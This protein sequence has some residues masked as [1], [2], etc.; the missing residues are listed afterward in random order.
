MKKGFLGLL[1]YFVLVCPIW[2]QGKRK[3][4]KSIAPMDVAAL[5]KSDS[6]RLETIIIDA[7]RELILD[8]G[9]K[10]LQLYKSA[11]ELSPNNPAVN[12]KIA[13]ILIKNG[14]SDQALL[15]AKKA[16]AGD[17]SNKYYL[18]LAAEAYKA[19]SDFKKASEI[20]AQMI[21]TVPGTESY[22]FDLAVLYQYQGEDEKALEAYDKAE[23]IFGMNEMV[24]HEKQ[25]IYLR[26]KDYESLIGDWDKL[27][28]ENKENERHT[29]ELCEFLISNRMFEE[30]KSRLA[31]LDGNK[32]ADLLMIR[33]LMIEGKISEAIGMAQ[34]TINSE[35]ASYM[36]KLRLLDDFLQYVETIEEYEQIT[37]FASRLTDQ[38]PRQYEVQAYAGDVM[39]RLGKEEEAIAY[40]LKAVSLDPSKYN[41]WQ[42][43]LN[44]EA[45]LGQY[46]SLAKHAE[47]AL[48]YFPNQ[49]A[50]YY[51][52]G[53]GHL[54]N[55]NYQKS[56][57]ML[58]QGIKYTKDPKFS[59]VFYGYIGDAHNGMKNHEKSYRAY[60]EALKSN[61]DNDHVLNN[62]SYFLS[63]RN[64]KMDKAL[65]M[66]SK[67]MEQYPD[68]P[69]YLDTHG[70]VLYV[71]GRYKEAIVYLRKATN[72]QENGTIIEHYGDVL[73][74]LGKVEDAVQQWK[75]ASKLEGVSKKIE[76]KIANKKLYE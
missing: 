21:E 59:T 43:I 71:M 17:P 38:Y 8:N 50:L 42:N 61:P 13:E 33:L 40:Y 60:E 11:L 27:V 16:M 57:Q 12:F 6:L 29:I 1:I 70:W 46:D 49:A 9:F 34:G 54:S 35:E 67:L 65:E 15:Y 44:I 22:L 68:N 62:Y 24:F 39:F 30:A 31:R 37:D 48:E 4:S 2:A 41:V 56:V 55:K 66:S 63:L 3:P 36:E 18:L 64:V 25:K 74:Q 7:Q 28:E 14:D 47:K 53:T 20:Y 45:G 76:K 69:T 72:L 23:E 58:N 5:S 32:R 10:A 75:R 19:I 73:F 52:A 51:F 26:Y